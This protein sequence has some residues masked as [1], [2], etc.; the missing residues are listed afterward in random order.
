[1]ID[2]DASER[3]AIRS[4]ESD[5]VEAAGRRT[6]YAPGDPL[7][8]LYILRYGWAISEYS[9]GDGR[10]QIV[11]V[12]LPGDVIG[13]CELAG[14]IAVHNVYMRTDGAFSRA[15]RTLVRDV[16]SETPRLGAVLT[17]VAAQDQLAMA[18]QLHAHARLSAIERLVTFLL[19][20]RA[21]ISATQVGT[22][23]RFPLP[24]TQVEIANHLG[25]S[26]VWVSKLMRRLREEGR[27]EYAGQQVRLTDAA[28]LAREVG[29]TDI[30]L[31]RRASW[32]P[33][34]CAGQEVPESSLPQHAGD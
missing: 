32:I 30:H 6:V 23:T 12:H 31:P 15:P 24:L 25:L 19:S 16:L 8:D 2:L 10:R 20:L 34:R 1:M 21:R 11:R 4:L 27:I 18:Q 33:E 17:A 28:R 29:F 7:S 9:A 13:L 3:A 22:V 14:K 26:P 5:V